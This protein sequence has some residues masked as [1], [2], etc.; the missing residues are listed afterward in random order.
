MEKKQYTCPELHTLAMSEKDI[1]SGSDVLI[2]GSDLFGE[3]K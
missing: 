1:L 2:D 3:D